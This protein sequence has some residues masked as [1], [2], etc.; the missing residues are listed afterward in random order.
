L[1]VRLGS[2]LWETN[3][4]ILSGSTFPREG[5]N[6]SYQYARRQWSLAKKDF[7]KYHWLSDFDKAMLQFVKENHVMSAAPPWKLYIDNE[8]KT[9][10]YERNK[11]IFVFNWHAMNALPDY[12]IPL[13]DTGDYKVILSTDDIAFWWL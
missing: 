3:L 5:N 13:K 11:L 7:L 8:N 12:E 4:D 1:V 9:I 10:V 2:T 6:W